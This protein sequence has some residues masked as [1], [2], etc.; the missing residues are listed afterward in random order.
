M[1]EL[2]M[3]IVLL[4]MIVT[5]TV[6]I[7][8]RMLASTSK[9][10]NQTVGLVFAQR[11]LE[12][13]T[14]IGPPETPGGPG[15]GISDPSEVLAEGVY[16]PDDRLQTTFWNRLTVQPLDERPVMP[17]GGRKMGDLYRLRVEVY[18]WASDPNNPQP[19]VRQGMGVQK[20]E[21]ETIYYYQRMK[22]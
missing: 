15:W 10:T 20:V 17:D 19:I 14:Q 8:T 22:D 18:W 13:A 21:L 9:T 3:A 7:F 1:A 4:G 12:Q 2:V 11:R 6:L 16:T 5:V